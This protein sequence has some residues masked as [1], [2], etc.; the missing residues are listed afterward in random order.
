M[1]GAGTIIGGL[2]LLINMQDRQEEKKQ[3]EATKQTVENMSNEPV[4]DGVSPEVQA[5]QHTKEAVE[6]LA[7]IRAVNE[8]GPEDTDA[9]VSASV[10]LNDGETA[11]ITVTPQDGQWLYVK[12]VH[13]DRYE[14]HVYTINVGGD[15]S[16]V[17]HRAVYS[18]PRVVQ[19]GDRIIAEVT[20]NSG[21][22]TTLDFEVEAWGE[23]R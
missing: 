14:D 9:Y 16:S 15:V 22:T 12:K 10:T 20:N 4:P 3:E 7:D 17:S 18:K 1:V 11:E 8:P 21:S 6:R 19:G 2:S 23:V 5:Q 13:L